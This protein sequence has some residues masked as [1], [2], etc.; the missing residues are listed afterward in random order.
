MA[1]RPSVPTLLGDGWDANTSSGRGTA[2]IA[3]EP[4]SPT[5]LSGDRYVIIPRT[6]LVLAWRSL[7]L[8]RRRALAAMLTTPMVCTSMK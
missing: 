1:S 7:R 6:T 3:V 5:R 2:V 8:A 4:R